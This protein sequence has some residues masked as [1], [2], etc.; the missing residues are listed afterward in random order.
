MKKILI[1]VIFASSLAM[2][3]DV[4]KCS[5]AMKDYTYWSDRGSN[6]ESIGKE[7]QDFTRRESKFMRYALVKEIKAQ[8]KNILPKKLYDGYN[9]ETTKDV[10]NI[11][12]GKFTLD[13]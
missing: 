1:G 4:M 9:L 5:K 13:Y 8:C 10:L 11:E 3:G 12:Y 2:S 7:Y 6:Y